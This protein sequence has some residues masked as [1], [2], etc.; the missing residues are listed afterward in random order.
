MRSIILTLILL[1]SVS[2]LVGQKKSQRVRKLERERLQMLK[3]IEN[4]DRKL[5][6]V[7]KDAHAQQQHLELVRRQVAQ[8]SEMVKMLGN[9][10]TALEQ[11]IDSL[12]GQIRSLHA[13]EQGLLE[14][15]KRSVRAI[16]RGTG[17][18]QQLLFIFSASGLQKGIQ[19]QRFLSRYASSSHR[20]VEQL[21]RTRRAIHTKQK[22]LNATHESK[23]ELQAQRDNERKKLEDEA[24]QRVAQV[25]S[26]KHQE[27]QL[28]QNLAQQQIKAQELERKIE[29]QIAREIALAEQARANKARRRAEARKRAEQRKSNSG[30][31]KRESPAKR[32]DPVRAVEPED[33]S[34]SASRDAEEMDVAD[35][36]EIKLSGSFARNKGRLPMPVRGRYQIVRRFGLQQHGTHSRVKISSGGIDVKPSSD[37]RA[38]AVFDGVVGSIFVT[39][40]Y[41]SSLIIRH[42]DYRTTYTNLSTINVRKGQQIKAGA[43]IGTI[44]N[45]G[46]G[47]R[48]GSL[49]FQLWYGRTKQDPLKWLKR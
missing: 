9:E 43:V 42:G 12:S 13:H 38:Y 11:D 34:S 26:L 21:R 4:T 40:G 24:H 8:R 19:R 30:E 3:D 41:G 27:S 47:E 15:Y 31:H 48:A 14:Q 5:K 32:N 17:T 10:I 1:C 36:Q 7:K 44:S 25:A 18:E 37:R 49:H 16:A 33:N 6:A 35:V 2:T 28:E 46:V 45:E 39:P 29:Q 23:L 22:E 20:S